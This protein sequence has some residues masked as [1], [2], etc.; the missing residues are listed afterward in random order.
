MTKITVKLAGVPIGK[1]RPKFARRGK[2][3]HTYSPARTVSYEKQLEEAARKVW[4]SEPLI[5]ALVVKVTAVFP[6]PPSWPKKSRLLA[7][8]GGMW[9]LSKPDLDNIF[10]IVGDGL[11]GVLWADDASI[12]SLS[13]VKFYGKEPALYV[14]VETIAV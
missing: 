5:G 8:A 12:C 7:E 4:K 13:G 14:E 1:G 6:I 3:V 11:N 9:H 2:G 10:K